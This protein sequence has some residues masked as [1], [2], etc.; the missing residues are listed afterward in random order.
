MYLNRC[1]YCGDNGEIRGNYCVRCKRCSTATRTYSTEEQA[2]E[3]WNRHNFKYSDDFL[4]LERSRELGHASGRVE[5]QKQSFL[6]NRICRLREEKEEKEMQAVN[7]EFERQ[8]QELNC[9]DYFM[10]DEE[11]RRI[12]KEKIRKE[13]EYQNREADRSRDMPHRSRNHYDLER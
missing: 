6:D 2:V 7:E 4:C 9:Q 11:K 1:P 5:A 13:F 12:L 8:I 3:A 10:L